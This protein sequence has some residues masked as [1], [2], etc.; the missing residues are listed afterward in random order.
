MRDTGT[1]P[2][3]GNEALAVEGPTDTKISGQAR[4]VA[5]ILAVACGQ[6]RACP[7]GSKVTAHIDEGS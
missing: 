7:V 2:N 6:E 5:G 3:A 1:G 4:A